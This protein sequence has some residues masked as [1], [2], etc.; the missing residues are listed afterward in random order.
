[1]NSVCAS[2]L[3]RCA[4]AVRRPE[5]VRGVENESAV[6]APL[7]ELI[8]ETED[9]RPALADGHAIDPALWRCVSIN[10]LK[11][12]VGTKASWKEV[13]AGIAKLKGLVQLVPPPC[14]H[15]SR[16][17]LSFPQHPGRLLCT[18][19]CGCRSEQ[20]VALECSIAHPTEAQTVP[21][22]F[23]GAELPSELAATGCS[24]R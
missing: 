14:R 12:R 4:D 7:K 24:C 6:G 2:G 5:V 1:M 20:W 11:L 21:C 17:G 9:A 8:I 18:R 3:V 19:S 15:C 23:A 10:N 13:P 22:R 16:Q